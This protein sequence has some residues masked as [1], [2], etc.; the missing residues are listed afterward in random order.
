MKKIQFSVLFLV[1][2][3]SVF[4]QKQRITLQKQ[5]FELHNVT[6]SII[7]FEGKDVLKIER[8]LKA[9]P[10]MS[11]IS[12][13]RLMNLIMPGLSALRTLRTARLK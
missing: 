7:K 5:I 8:D 12:K 6:G 4:G 10:L 2:T 3:M 1:F 13:G 11:I 9:L